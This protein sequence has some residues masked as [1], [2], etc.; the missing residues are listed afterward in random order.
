M[1]DFTC[2]IAQ[3]IHQ[4]GVD[5]LRRAGIR[6]IDAPA[7]DP[8]SVGALLGD[9]DAL[10][11]RSA[12]VN[13]AMLAGAPRLKVIGVH[14]VGVDAIDIPAATDHGTVVANTPAATP[15]RWRNRPSR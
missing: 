5:V 10:I 13:R 9:A 12:A 11:V 8:G 3:P 14:G 15:R 1:T 2:V 7:A 4:D 6:V